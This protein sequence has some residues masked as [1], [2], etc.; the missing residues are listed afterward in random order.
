MSLLEFHPKGLIRGTVLTSF[1]TLCSR[2]F[3]VASFARIVLLWQPFCVPQELEHAFSILQYASY[4]VQRCIA[5]VPKSQ[6]LSTRE[7][8]RFAQLGI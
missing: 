8:Q 3:H 5:L 4:S 6:N 2:A 7:A 1:G